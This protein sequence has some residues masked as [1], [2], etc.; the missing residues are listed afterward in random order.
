ML[1]VLRPR[2]RPL[3]VKHRV[4]L[5]SVEDD[6]YNKENDSDNNRHQG[7]VPR[8]FCRLAGSLLNVGFNRAGRA[9]EGWMPGGEYG[10]L[11]SRVGTFCAMLYFVYRK[12]YFVYGKSKDR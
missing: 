1:A 6:V 10:P 4:R 7:G 3:S 2:V 9:G 12:L 11:L 8:S 5:V